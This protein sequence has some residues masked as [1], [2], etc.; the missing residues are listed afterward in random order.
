MNEPSIEGLLL[1]L[2]G[3]VGLGFGFARREMPLNFRVDTS[4]DRNPVGFWALAGF[5]G[6]VVI[7]GIMI[8]IRY[9]R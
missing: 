9:A 7:V 8:A 2:V 5:Y 4:R 6:F 1:A 3:L